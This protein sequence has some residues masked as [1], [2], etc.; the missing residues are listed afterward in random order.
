[1]VNLT[2]ILRATFALAVNF[3]NVKRANFT[4][5][6]IIQQ[7]FLLTRN[8]QKDIRTKYACIKRWRNW[9]LYYFAKKLQIQLK[10]VSREKLRKT[11]SYKKAASKVL[12]KSL[13]YLRFF[14][15]QFTFGSVFWIKESRCLGIQLPSSGLELYSSKPVVL[16]FNGLI[17]I[18]GTKLIFVFNFVKYIRDLYILCLVVHSSQLPCYPIW[19]KLTLIQDFIRYF[20]NRLKITS[21]FRCRQNR[22]KNNHQDMVQILDILWF[23]LISP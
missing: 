3:I 7:L 13:F 16:I 9:H 15:F 11:F 19:V 4:Y 5:K 21:H 12:V 20:Y 18:N 17:Q 23:D 14:S 22:P 6:S 8:C 1:M 2:N 10:H